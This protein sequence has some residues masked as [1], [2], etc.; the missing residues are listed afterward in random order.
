[1]TTMD[2]VK[3]LNYGSE[4][5]IDE[6]IAKHIQEKITIHK[7]LTQFE[8]EWIGANETKFRKRC[9]SCNDEKPLTDFQGNT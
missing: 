5:P 2:Y 8:N 1:M 3:L 7:R 4:I 9:F 6:Q